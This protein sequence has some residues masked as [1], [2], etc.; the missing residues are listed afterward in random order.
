MDYYERIDRAIDF[1]ERRLTEPL[2]LGDVA[3]CACF[4]LFHFHRVFQAII[5]CSVKEYIRRRRLHIASHELGATNARILDIALKY[6]YETHESFTRAF[7]RQYGM[8]P[9]RYRTSLTEVA[10]FDRADVHAIKLRH[11]MGDKKMEPKI[12][13][14]D[15]FKVIGVE[16]RTTICN[17]ENVQAIPEFWDQF[18]Q[19]G[20][21]RRI[22]N[23]VN[24]NALL[25]VCGDSDEDGSF[26][27]IICAEVSSFDEAPDGMVARTVPAAKYA[28]FTS[29]GK[30]PDSVQDMGRYIFGTWLPKSGYEHADTEDF[31]V[32]DERFTGLEDSEVDIYIPIK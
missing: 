11:M 13:N 29:K 23:R 9:K 14:R 32:Y 21:D 15:A 16:L 12:V 2:S 5:G 3:R 25:G 17:G 8:T 19:D 7:K 18:A 27:Y 24:H 6:Q 22:P 31:E 20:A 30:V 1:I 28:V 26:S 10:P 4:S